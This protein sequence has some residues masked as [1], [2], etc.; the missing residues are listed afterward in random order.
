[1]STTPIN[2]LVAAAFKRWQLSREVRTEPLMTPVPIPATWTGQDVIDWIQSQFYIPET[3]GAMPLADYQQV[4]LREAHRRDAQGHFIYDLV[5]WS[6]IKK[7]IKSCIAAAVILFRAL[8]TDYGSFYIVANDLKQANSRVFYF[9]LRALELNKE[10][11]NRASIRNYKIQLD[12]HSFIE[13]IP[14]DPK[15]EAGANPDMIEFTE[16]HA[17]ETK[18]AASMWTEMT[19]SPIKHGFSQRWVDTYAGHSGESPIL[20]PLYQTIVKEGQQID[21]GISDLEVY[22]NGSQLALWNTRPRLLWQDE[23]YYASEAKTLLPNEF[24]RIHRN[25]WT[26]SASVFVPG[27]WWDA[28]R[29]EYPVFDRNTPVVVG[30]DAGV[31]NDCFAIVGVSRVQDGTSDKVYVRF[32][33]VW[34][35]PKNGKIDFA[36]PE[37]YIKNELLP[38]YNIVQVAYDPHQLVDMA[39]RFQN[40]GLVWMYEFNQGEPRLRADKQLYDGIRDR[41]LVHD[42][43]PDLTEHVRNANAKT[44]GDIDKLRIV[45]RADHLKIDCCVALSMCNSEARRLSIA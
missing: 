33:R 27:E 38:H 45:K 12:T 41:Q 43:Q 7:S 5:L 23:S 4:V 20:E 36:E 40:A 9:I 29:G 8:H 25:Q 39:R 13:A 6:D 24:D 31:S 14:V 16:L 18:A 26:T 11:G 1:M 2:P 34:R 19:L 10:L 42:G 3:R 44:E 37:A 21:L 28:C 22:A 15:G 17:A 30:M 32:V 35:P